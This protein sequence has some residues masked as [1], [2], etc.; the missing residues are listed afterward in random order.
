MGDS[1]L[2]LSSGRRPLG[3][4]SSSGLKTSR[5]ASE[6]QPKAAVPAFAPH[7]PSSCAGSQISTPLSAILLVGHGSNWQAAD[8]LAV[9]VVSLLN[10]VRKS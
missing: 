1:R 3:F 5:G 2:R 6:G 10:S 4:Q 9:M 8:G 7:T